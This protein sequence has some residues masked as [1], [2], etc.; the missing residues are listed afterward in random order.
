MVIDFSEGCAP[1]TNL[2]QLLAHIGKRA[3]PVC[4]IGLLFILCVQINGTEVFSLTLSGK[5]YKK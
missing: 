4:M 1:Q 3:G 5:V 2:C